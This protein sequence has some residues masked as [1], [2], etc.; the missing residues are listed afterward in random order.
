MAVLTIFALNYWG[1]LCMYFVER[2]QI[3]EDADQVQQILLI[4]KP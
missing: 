3:E 4:N 2:E 1:W